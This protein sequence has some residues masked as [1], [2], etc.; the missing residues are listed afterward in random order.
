M[1]LCPSPYSVPADATPTSTVAEV[2][3]LWGKAQAAVRT[4]AVSARVV[5]LSKW[6]V[7]DDRFEGESYRLREKRRAG[8]FSCTA[9]WTSTRKT[10]T[11][12]V[13]NVAG[14]LA[15]TDS[16]SSSGVGP[17]PVR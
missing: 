4:E 1:E 11:T 2:H 10:T 16:L 5:T 8:L 3:R 12:P 13:D 7:G 14:H 15:R 9:C 6:N 17:I